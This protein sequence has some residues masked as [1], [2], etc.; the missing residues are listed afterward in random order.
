M[1]MTEFEE[2]EIPERLRLYSSA[3][4]AAEITVTDLQTRIKEI[5]ASRVQ[6]T[7]DL[8]K[9]ILD[10][11]ISNVK[12]HI[13]RYERDSQP[14]AQLQGVINELGT[15][16]EKSAS[17]ESARSRARGWRR[18]ACRNFWNSPAAVTR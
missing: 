11:K 15:L 16:G 4:N 14:Y 18:D 3:L 2:Q 6:Q 12:S 5:E 9:K 8:K 17:Y 1:G 7:N 10:A 13:D